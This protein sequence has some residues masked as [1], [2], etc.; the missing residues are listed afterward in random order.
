M[1]VN[2]RQSGHTHWSVMFL[3]AVNTNFLNLKADKKD[4]VG[5]GPGE[6]E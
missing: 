1:D 5:K 4:R 6:W 2:R 3:G